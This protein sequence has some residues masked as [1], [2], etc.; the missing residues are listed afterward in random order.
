M[1]GFSSSKQR[2]CE[3]SSI[4]VISNPSYT[5]VSTLVIKLYAMSFK[6]SV[7]RIFTCTY[8]TAL[9][10]SNI[11]ALLGRLLQQQRALLH[12]LEPKLNINAETSHFR[13][14]STASVLL[15]M[16]YCE[17]FNNIYLTILCMKPTSEHIIGNRQK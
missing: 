1:S 17:H 11:I 10:I 8:G 5:V 7:Y 3:S 13:S 15:A 4:L 2:E 6:F 16:V 14:D 12:S 9:R